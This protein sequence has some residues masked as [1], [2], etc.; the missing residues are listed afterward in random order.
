MSD[1]QKRL[2]A[3]KRGE[4]IYEGKPCKHGHGVKRYTSNGVCIECTA[5]RSTERTGKIRDALR[6]AK[7]DAE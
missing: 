6:E 3:A 5:L 2:E 4:T 1:Y 7:A